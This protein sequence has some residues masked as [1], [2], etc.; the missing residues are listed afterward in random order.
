MRENY[1][2]A[3]SN[4]TYKIVLSRADVKVGVR[5]VARNSRSK[6]GGGERV[7]RGGIGAVQGRGCSR[8]MCAQHPF[9]NCNRRHIGA[10]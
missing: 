7:I 5:K 8:G 4:P 9:G 1:F 2:A 10:G 3:I 6:R